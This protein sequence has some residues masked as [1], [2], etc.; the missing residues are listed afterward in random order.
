MAE[1][2]DAVNALRPQPRRGDQRIID[3]DYDETGL[4][5]DLAALGFYEVPRT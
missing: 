5:E 3:D 2:P 1:K 4:A